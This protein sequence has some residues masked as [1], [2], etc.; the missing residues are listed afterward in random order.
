MMGVCRLK[1]ASLLVTAA[2]LLP[3]LCNAQVTPGTGGSLRSLEP[4]PLA[5]PPSRLEIPIPDT[6]AV[7]QA[8]AGVVKRFRVT[9]LSTVSEREI[10]T[11]LAPWTGKTLSAADLSAV[12][13]AVRRDL[14]QRG[15]YAADAYFPEQTVVD[16]V[17]DIGVFEG[18]IG[19]I[20]LDMDKDTRLKRTVAEGY[21]SR[22]QPDGLIQRGTFDSALLLLNDLPGVRASP[23][24]TRGNTPG[25]ADLQVRV[26]DEPMATG[27]VQLDNHEIRELGE[28]R[29]TGH[30]RLRDPLGIGDL[31]TAQFTQTH[32]SDRK[33]GAVT[34]SLP[35]GNWGTRVGA[36]FATHQYRLGGDFEA[37][38]ANGRYTSGQVKLTHP[39]AR[40][41][42]ANLT[43]ELQFDETRYHDSIDAVST[44]SDFRYRLL[45]LTVH[46]DK[47]DDFL[48]GGVTTF[49]AQYRSGRV[50]LDTPEV[51]ADDAT[52][53]GLGGHFTRGRFRLARE[54][55][56]SE[57]MGLS[58]SLLTQ[59]AS[60]NLEGGLKF[61]LGGPDG[62]RAYGLSE[63][64][65]DE[66]HLARLD[67]H[68][69]RVLNSVWRAKGALFV[70]SARGRVNKNPLAGSSDNTQS[71]T[72]YG[73]SLALGWR[74][75][76]QS[77]ITFAKPANVPAT[78]TQRQLRIWASLRYMF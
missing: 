41:N 39:F 67:L 27:Y 68:H 6:T 28:Y 70:D 55:A 52:G 9:G 44:R 78:D 77:E 63:L 32:T 13:N 46:A 74:D 30:L 50:Y 21:L 10:V 45:S 22:L 34:Y 38:G 14:R 16:G 65:V 5:Q 8:L 59:H 61:Q 62:V 7:T 54:Q 1:R 17:V 57:T 49:Y 31:A 11:L 53:L 33:L 35:V 37:L 73:V 75:K 19:A 26:D 51:A 72:G 76:V 42:D 20:T 43:G 18:R 12:L 58:V 71:L 4:P 47:A 40:T 29:L 36:R 2:L 24:L 56:L 69:T 64:F 23:S 60:K 66:G 15:L 25:V 3:L 48:R